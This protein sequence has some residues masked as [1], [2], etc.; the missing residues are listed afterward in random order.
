ML[1]AIQRRVLINGETKAK[2]AKPY[3]HQG[4]DRSDRPMDLLACLGDAGLDSSSLWATGISF[5]MDMSIQMLE[6][7]PRINIA[8][9]LA[10]HDLN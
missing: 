4:T 2:N 1:R 5:C 3:A 9:Y 10:L 6:V 8:L 7:F